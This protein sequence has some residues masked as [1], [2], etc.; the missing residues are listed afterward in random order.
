MVEEVV[1]LRTLLILSVSRIKG[2]KNILIIW[3][4]LSTK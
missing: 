2:A 3:T 1:T 4:N